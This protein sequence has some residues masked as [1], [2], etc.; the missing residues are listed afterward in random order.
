M[1][2]GIDSDKNMLAFGIKNKQK[3][4]MENASFLL[5]DAT[6]L[7]FED[8]RFD[9]VSVSFA[10]HDKLPDLRRQV[11]S[12]MVRVVKPQGFLLL[13]DFNVPL[14]FNIW[15]VAASTVEFLAGGTHYQGF[16]DFKKNNGLH[17]IIEDNGLTEI[18]A[19]YFTGRMVAVVKAHVNK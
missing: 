3:L 19:D 2:I 10:L 14:P 15:G 9:Y 16:K 7:P 5:A 13:M 1:A 11:V 4:Q 17:K 6:A 18:K 8:N 12:E